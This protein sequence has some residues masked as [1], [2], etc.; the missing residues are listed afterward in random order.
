[1]DDRCLTSGVFVWAACTESGRCDGDHEV[2]FACT[3][4]GFILG[5]NPLSMLGACPAV[6]SPALFSFQPTTLECGSVSD[7][8]LVLPASS[9][10]LV[11]IASIIPSSVKEA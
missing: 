5:V 4:G 11:Q 7:L 10:S 2:A 9:S 8:E 1:M 3:S 6:I